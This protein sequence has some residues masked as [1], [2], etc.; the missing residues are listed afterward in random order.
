MP[1]NF[2]SARLT[3]TTDCAILANAVP[4]AIATKMSLLVGVW[5]ESD[6][7]YQ[8]EKQAL[9]TAVQQHGSAWLIGVTVGF[10]NVA[11]GVAD[12]NQLI[13]Q[14]G[15]IRTT[16]GTTA[17][18][19]GHIEDMPGW[20]S[21]ATTGLV[22]ACDFL[23]VNINPYL[24]AAPSSSSNQ[25]FWSSVDA[26]WSVSQTKPVWVTQ[27]AWPVKGPTN[28][29]A[30]P[31]VENAKNY[32]DEAL[33]QAFTEV[34]TFLNLL[35]DYNGMPSYGVLDQNWR[36]IYDT[37]CPPTNSALRLTAPTAAPRRAPLQEPTQL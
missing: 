14:I 1:G 2:T 8:A 33:C 21:V 10:E 22:P 25:T 36:M 37:Q 15:Q 35:Q 26:I 30:S 6:A 34:N 11:R 17:V 29:N 7:I 20:T 5:T 16:I 31:S 3:N 28:G 19:V 18:P 4:A 12:V 23:G 27:S 24:P 32:Y 13:S 9:L